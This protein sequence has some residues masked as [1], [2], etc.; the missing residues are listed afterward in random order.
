[1][2]CHF[3]NNTVLGRSSI[4]Y[5][6]IA[7]DIIE[8]HKELQKPCLITPMAVWCYIKKRYI[9]QQ[10]QEESQLKPQEEHKSFQDYGNCDVGYNWDVS[11][12][13]TEDEA[14]NKDL[15]NQKV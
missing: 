1:M 9:K 11:D 8:I 4:V 5:K 7:Q 14:L 13:E 3:A 15:Y 2:K 6:K 10:S 12:M